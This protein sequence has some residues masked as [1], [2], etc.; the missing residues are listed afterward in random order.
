[1]LSGC[2]CHQLDLGPSLDTDQGGPLSLKIDAHSAVS[3]FQWPIGALLACSL[4]S[5]GLTPFP[6]ESSMGVKVE[7]MYD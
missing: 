4:L 2:D 5:H 1:V 6:R 7:Q 3:A